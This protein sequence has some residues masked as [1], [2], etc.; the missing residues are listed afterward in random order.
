LLLA[1]GGVLMPPAKGERPSFRGVFSRH[2]AQG[3]D[4]FSFGQE[5]KEKKDQVAF[6]DCLILGLLC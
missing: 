2:P 1:G 6:F 4:L 3:K 5:K